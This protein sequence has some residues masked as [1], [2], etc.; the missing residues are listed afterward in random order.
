MNTFKD[1]DL[2]EALR[3][4]YAD[5]PQM[6]DSLRSLTP[7]P[8]QREREQKRASHTWR[9]TAVWGGLL[10]VA[11]SIAFLLVLHFGNNPS[12]EQPMVVQAPLKSEM[13][14]DGIEMKKASSNVPLLGGSRGAPLNKPKKVHRKAVR[15]SNFAMPAPADADRTLAEAEPTPEEERPANLRLSPE[16][17]VLLAMEAR[18]Q[19]FRSRGKRL[20]REIEELMNN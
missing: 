1:T 7:R 8:L 11:A 19:D 15:K 13:K 2:R 9:K 3:R 20:Q 12:E 16:E 10:A 17:E 6:P 18:E 14:D 4:K 5:V